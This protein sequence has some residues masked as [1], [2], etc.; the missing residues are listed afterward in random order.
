MTQKEHENHSGWSGDQSF[1][2]ELNAS[3]AYIKWSTL[4]YWCFV[5]FAV[6]N[7]VTIKSTM[8]PHHNIH[9]FTWMSPDGNSHNHI[10]H[11]LIEDSIQVYLMFDHS[12]QQI[13]ILTAI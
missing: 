3:F 2:Q 7:N 12:G 1:G 4:Q 13:V 6:F 8:F 11:I 9:K 5:N 10:H